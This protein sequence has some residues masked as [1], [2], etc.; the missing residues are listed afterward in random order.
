M[1]LPNFPD[2]MMEYEFLF[3]LSGDSLKEKR[4]N[5]M[6]LFGKSFVYREKLFNNGDLEVYKFLCESKNLLAIK[7]LACIKEGSTKKKFDKI[8]K[9][10]HEI[11]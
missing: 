6:L 3:G 4:Y 7:K 11:L 9:P 10:I 2:N 5:L 8:W 1:D